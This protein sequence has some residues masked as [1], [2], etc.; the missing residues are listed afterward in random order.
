MASN[1]QDPW[2]EEAASAA[3]AAAGGGGGAGGKPARRINLDL[4]AE[5]VP[6]SRQTAALQAATVALVE[7]WV[8]Q[9][10]GR[11]G[12]EQGMSALFLAPNV[13]ATDVG[14][15]GTSATA[16]GAAPLLSGWVATL[17]PE[18]RVPRGGGGVVTAALGSGTSWF[19]VAS[20]SV[21][22]ARLLRGFRAAGAVADLPAGVSVA[23]VSGKED[24]EPVHYIVARG[25][26]AAAAS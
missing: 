4:S 26:D 10:L 25:N 19:R 3:A 13:T 6:E 11:G 8:S 5:F 20:A 18:A 12:T 14:A 23:L 9:R 15:V 24:F 2:E 21:D 17:H 22:E 16:A 7:P 1:G